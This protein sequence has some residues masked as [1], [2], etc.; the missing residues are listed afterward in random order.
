[1]LGYKTLRIGIYLTHT[2]MYS[3]FKLPAVVWKDKIVVINDLT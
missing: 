2:F 3:I 1:M